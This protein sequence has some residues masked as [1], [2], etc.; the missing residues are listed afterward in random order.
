[1]QWI[2]DLPY[3]HA[4]LTLGLVYTTFYSLFSTCRSLL[5]MVRTPR[6]IGGMSISGDVSGRRN[7]F[8]RSAIGTDHGLNRYNIHNDTYRFFS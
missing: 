4:V 2:T 6:S 8:M 7:K 5:R 1:M 3:A